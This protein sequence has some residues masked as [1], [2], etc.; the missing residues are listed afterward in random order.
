MTIERLLKKQF[1]NRKL[2]PIS[3]SD[4]IGKKKLNI[5]IDLLFGYANQVETTEWAQGL[6]CFQVFWFFTKILYKIKKSKN[7][8][9]NDNEGKV[10]SNIKRDY[11][12]HNLK[13]TNIDVISIKSQKKRNNQKQ[14]A[15]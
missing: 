7:P 4:L 14:W 2:I 5:S 8:E 11:K 6:I 1:E 13:L 15:D 3:T 9:T 10:R 12:Y